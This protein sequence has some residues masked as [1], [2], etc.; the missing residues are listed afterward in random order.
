MKTFL[1][2]LVVTFGG[3]VWAQTN[4]DPI[5]DHQSKTYDANFTPVSGS[6]QMTMTPFF[7]PDWSLKTLVD[8]V[9]N[10]KTTIDIGTPSFRG[11]NNCTKT[12]PGQCYGC[13]VQEVFETESFTL[14]QALI[15]AVHR[16]VKVR[17]MTNDYG[18]SICQGLIGPE[19]YLKVAGADIRFFTTVSFL[20]TK[21]LNVDGKKSA[22]SS[23][24]WSFTSFNENREAGVIIE[25]EDVVSFV[26]SV[27][28]ADF[29]QSLPLVP[30]FA[31]TAA[32]MDIIQ[33]KDV[34]I[35]YPPPYPFA[36]DCVTSSPTPE[37][38]SAVADYTVFASPDHSYTT[39]TDIIN[40]TKTSMHLS[41][42]EI[43]SPEVCSALLEAA[44]RI[45]T[46]EIF[47]SNYVVSYGEYE[48]SHAC[49]KRL[50]QA[51]V[52]VVESKK[53]CFSFSHQKYFVSDGD[54][55]TL[56]TGNMAPSDYPGGSM[57]F[58]PFT[59]G[60][61]WRKVNRDYTIKLKNKDIADVFMNVFTED[62]NQ[63]FKFIPYSFHHTDDL[64][65]S[66][67]Q[68]NA[69]DQATVTNQKFDLDAALR[70]N[71]SAKLSQMLSSSC[72]P[73]FQSWSQCAANQCK[74]EC[75]NGTTSKC[76]SCLASQCD[77]ALKQCV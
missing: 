39:L 35:T 69:K 15:N 30:P 50:Y 22:I 8:L 12:A 32:E 71:D 75:S 37:P 72:A 20:H 2:L 54:Q 60:S 61:A 27:F 47:V 4:T 68:C 49:Y 26:T 62:Y 53:Y 58:P 52:S 11:W 19:T 59:A 34:K 44:S 10:A 40:S 76:Q 3:L 63:G 38:V 77:A 57:V 7:S 24:N 65:V 5:Y 56:S 9:Q 25:N 45:E 51:N 70:Q 6:G 36:A 17:L 48:A 42:Y 18:N 43:T 1:L 13:T 29:A 46:M 33:N 16:G 55:V 41:I 23:V 73:C 74:S 21:Y 64:F 67:L 14:W 28:E 66:S 31:Y